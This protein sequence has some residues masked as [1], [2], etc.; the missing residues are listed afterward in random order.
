MAGR[1]LSNISVNMEVEL[2][3]P[4]FLKRSNSAPMINNLN[5]SNS[6]GNINS[7]QFAGNR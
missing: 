1:E 2:D 3:T 5:G 6:N 7:S 4:G